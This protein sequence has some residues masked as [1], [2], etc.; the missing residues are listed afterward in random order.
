V[1]AQPLQEVSAPPVSVPSLS[2]SPSLPACA[3]RCLMFQQSPQERKGLR[4]ERPDRLGARLPRPA[5]PHLQEAPSPRALDVQQLPD[6]VHRKD[7]DLWRMRLQPGRHGRPR[8]VSFLRPPRGRAAN[9]DEG[10]SPRK[11][12]YKPTDLEV[13]RLNDRLKQTSLSAA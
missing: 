4:Q 2:L 9:A 10:D 3:A 11:P 5:P 7:Q 12:R 1:Q 6:D 13:Q 8:P